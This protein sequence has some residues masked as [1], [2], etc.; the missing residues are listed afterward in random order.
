MFSLARV[1]SGTRGTCYGDHSH[2]QSVWGVPTA[3]CVLLSRTEVFR[4]FFFF[5]IRISRAFFT[6][7][8]KRSIELRLL[9]LCT[10]QCSVLTIVLHH[11]GWQMPFH[12]RN[13][14]K[15]LFFFLVLNTSLESNKKKSSSWEMYRVYWHYAKIVVFEGNLYHWRL[16]C[17]WHL[18]KA[19]VPSSLLK[20]YNQNKERCL[21][22]YNKCFKS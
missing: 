8:E 15:I 11:K 20:Q 3:S 6:S 2:C 5:F 7:S 17:V 9:L 21:L 22:W 13:L 16:I 10:R 1:T 4:I 18:C 14:S 19:S 12:E